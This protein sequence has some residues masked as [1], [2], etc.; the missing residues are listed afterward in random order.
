MGD[1]YGFEDDKE[2]IDST[3]AKLSELANSRSGKQKKVKAAS[4]T[5]GSQGEKAPEEQ[6]PDRFEAKTPGDD[7]C[8][9]FNFEIIKHYPPTRSFQIKKPLKKSFMDS[10]FD[11]LGKQ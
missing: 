8:S 4:K 10:I 1:D 3:A 2:E 6:A 5:G 11:L 9:E 7:D